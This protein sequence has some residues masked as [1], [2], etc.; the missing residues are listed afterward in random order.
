MGQH[1]LE[2]QALQLNRQQT[3]L[4]DTQVNQLASII[5]SN[6]AIPHTYLERIKNAHRAELRSPAHAALLFMISASPSAQLARDI[7]DNFSTYLSQISI[8]NEAHFAGSDGSG[9]PYH[10]PVD[11][12]HNVPGTVGPV[13]ARVAYV[14]SPDENGH[15]ELVLVWKLEVE[16]ENN[17]YEAAVSLVDPTVIVEIVDW[18]SDAG[19]QPERLG[20]V[21]N[22]WKWGL[23]D[24]ECGERSVETSPY[25]EVASPLGW[26]SMPASKDARS[27]NKRYSKDHIL[28]ITQTY[29][30]NVY[31]HEDWEGRND[32]LDNYRPD[33][34]K[35]LM[36][37]YTYEL[38][39]K[40]G[41]W[42]DPK[43]YINLTITQLF[44]TTN[45]VHDLYY[46]YGFDEVAG[47][48]QQYN[49]GR[50]G[51][52]N[53]AVIANAQDGS[54]YNVRPSPFPSLPSRVLPFLRMPTL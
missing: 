3:P 4:G 14:Q 24:P 12:L 30:N 42:A 39:T 28:N 44:Y 43:S 40:N 20:G 7:T 52:E 27:R 35:E 21:Y 5:D 13:R 1:Y 46:R 47:N 11:Y 17:W 38:R 34:G 9:S 25:D 51:K 26:H 50:G 19:A 53:D 31:A 48:F 32:W 33:G 2:L 8:Q 29:G 15:T 6:C 37:N 36:F 16:M 22:V 41:S 49:F 18:A 54:G 10:Q 23:N 45:M